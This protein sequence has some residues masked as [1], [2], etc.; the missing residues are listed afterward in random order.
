MKKDST[1]MAIFGV[2]WVVY[3]S[4]IIVPLY[5][6]AASIIGLNNLNKKIDKMPRPVLFIVPLLI[7]TVL[8][9]WLDIIPFVKGIE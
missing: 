9:W 1:L 8:Y 4:L 7:S 2:I 6:I 5:F 3:N